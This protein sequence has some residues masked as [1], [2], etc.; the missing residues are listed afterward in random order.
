MQLPESEPKMDLSQKPKQGLTKKALIFGKERS[1]P[2]K[3]ALFGGLFIAVLTLLILTL[4]L[5]QSAKISPDQIPNT[6]P[7]EEILD[8]K[9]EVERRKRE[10]ASASIPINQLQNIYEKVIGSN[11]VK[12]TLEIN[13]SGVATIGYTITSVDGQTII[14]TSYE[15]F[16]DLAVRVFNIPTITRL[17][18]TTYANKLTDQF[19]QPNQTALKM[20]L[21]RETNGKINWPIKKFAYSDYLT[22]L[23][24]HEINPLLQKDYD[25]LTKKRN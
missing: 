15:N 14:K 10:E 7:E 19:G 24:L 4:A 17:N 1:L 22:I 20:Q 25:T 21:T 11:S 8:A 13:S 9:K 18:V 3:L 6:S 23:D 5:L 16:A 2:Q 12:K